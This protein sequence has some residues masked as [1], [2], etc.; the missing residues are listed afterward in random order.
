M[1]SDNKKRFR[2]FF[3]VGILLTLSEIIKQF[4]LTF[5]VNGGSYYWWYFPFQLCSIPMYL[6][7]LLPFLPARAQNTFL[8]F[9]ATFGLLGGIAAFA[10]TSGLHYTL[11]VLTAHSYLWHIV[12][13][14]TGLY[15]G[16][17]LIRTR[18]LCAGAFLVSALFYLLCCLAAIFINLTFDSYGTINMFYINP[19]YMMQQVIF[20]DIAVRLGNPA[21]IFLYIS[22]TICGAFLLFL[23]WK[24]AD[25]VR[26]KP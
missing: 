19:D 5:A 2:V 25:H 4:L 13:I 18:V 14:L 12:L 24:F 22:A 16:I 20:R 10:D 15:A 7:L 11:A 6:M 17:T 21:A 3:L 1:T 9:L 26:S 8:T 23:I